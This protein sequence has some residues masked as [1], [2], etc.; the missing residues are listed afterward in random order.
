[1][2]TVIIDLM[3]HGEKRGDLNTAFGLEQITAST[4]LHLRGVVL[5]AAYHSD[6]N[7]AREAAVQAITTLNQQVYMSN[8][9]GFFVRNLFSGEV[10]AELKRA[11]IAVGAN[12]TVADFLREC[13]GGPALARDIARSLMAVAGEVS[14]LHPGKTDLHALVGYHAPLLALPAV[15]P[16][17]MPIDMKL[18]DIVRYTLTND[19][20]GWVI[21]DSL[22]L[23]C[24]LVKLA[25]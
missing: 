13:D 24:P 7:R 10:G 3:R 22:H 20:S 23:P 9:L 8:H 15:N 1:M 11:E 6:M 18:A 12:G 17:A 19:G 5:D 4:K 14:L 25:P 16:E 2:R 21:T